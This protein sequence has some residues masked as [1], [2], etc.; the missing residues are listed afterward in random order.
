[1]TIRVNLDG[2]IFEISNE[3]FK[4]L[5]RHGDVRGD[6]PVWGR[7]FTD[8]EWWTAAD[9]RMFHLASPIDVPKGQHLIEEEDRR[10]ATAAEH[11]KQRRRVEEHQQAIATALCP[12]SIQALLADPNVQGVGRLWTS[13]AFEPARV[14]EVA[15]QPEH[16]HI[17]LRRAGAS[18][19]G[20]PQAPIAVTRLQRV[21]KLGDAPDPFKAWAE[22]KETA[23][24]S[25]S[26][27]TVALDG[28]G[29]S[30]S[31]VDRESAL[32]YVWANPTKHAHPEQMALI[33]A[34]NKLAS[35][36]GK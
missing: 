14:I 3:R 26:C 21:T 12:V 30:H 9:L 29:Y 2:E 6:T 23:S 11:A 15:F 32:S 22:Y 25:P 1:M 20:N 5:V 17:E 36:C 7:I 13:A 8:G 18:S 28:V 35:L 16:L 4:E 19:P 27:E 33:A 24:R 34:F 10:A 31:L